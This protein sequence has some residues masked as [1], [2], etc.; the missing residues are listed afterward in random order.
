MAATMISFFSSSTYSVFCFSGLKIEL[1]CGSQIMKS[2]AN[3]RQT[4]A[5]T[6]VLPSSLKKSCLVLFIC[7]F[8]FLQN[9]PRMGQSMELQSLSSFV[10]RVN[11]DKWL[12]VTSESSIVLYALCSQCFRNVPKNLNKDILYHYHYLFNQKSLLTN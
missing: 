5:H 9:C 8:F 6:F 11:E 1:N 4:T 3:A 12:D 10:S 7:N 2:L